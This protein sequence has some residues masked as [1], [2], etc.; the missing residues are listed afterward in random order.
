MEILD[1]SGAVVAFLNRDKNGNLEEIK[2]KINRNND[3]QG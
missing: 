2:P 1:S 3:I